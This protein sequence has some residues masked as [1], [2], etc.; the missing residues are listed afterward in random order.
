MFPKN[1][2]YLWDRRIVSY[3]FDNI[4]DVGTRPKPEI[5]VNIIKPSSTI[6]EVISFVLQSKLGDA[7]IEYV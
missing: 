5:S 6:P 3:G 1:P 2:H 4:H 7:K